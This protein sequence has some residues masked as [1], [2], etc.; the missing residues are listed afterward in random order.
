MSTNNSRPSLAARDALHALLQL[1]MTTPRAI[2]DIFVSYSPHCENVAVQVFRGGWRE[3]MSADHTWRV[4]FG[5]DSEDEFLALPGYLAQLISEWNTQPDN[6]RSRK[7][8]E[9]AARLEAEARQLET[10]GA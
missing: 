2:A 8:R 6:E 3:G 5:V 9:A 1:A 7:L 4:Y 10:A